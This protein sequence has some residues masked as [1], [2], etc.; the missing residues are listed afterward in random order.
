MNKQSWL[1]LAEIINAFRIIPRILVLVFYAFAGWY[2]QTVTAEYFVL[3]T[4]QDITEWKLAAFAGFA[5]ITIPAV[6]GF[7][8]KLTDNY[9]RTGNTNK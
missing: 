2:I 8:A 1:D 9:F 5:G 7:A 3:I 4:L 6:V